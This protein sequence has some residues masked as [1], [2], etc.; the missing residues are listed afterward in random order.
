[1]L[2]TGFNAPGVAGSRIHP[3]QTLRRLK[4][5]RS[6]ERDSGTGL[7][8]KTVQIQIVASHELTIFFRR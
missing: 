8:K 5:R 7:I 2:T 1:M 4:S 6:T 3:L